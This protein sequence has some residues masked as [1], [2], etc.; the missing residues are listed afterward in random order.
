MS[1]NGKFCLEKGD[2]PPWVFYLQGE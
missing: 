1:F 2:V